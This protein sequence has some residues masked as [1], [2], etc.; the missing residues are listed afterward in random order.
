MIKNLLNVFLL[1]VCFVYQSYSQNKNDYKIII[2]KK[3]WKTE[4][5]IPVKYLDDK[6]LNNG[7]L[8]IHFQSSFDHD[9]VLIKKNDEIYGR[10]ELTSNWILGNAKVVVIPDFEE[11]KTLTISI[12]GGKEAILDLNKMNQ[13]IITYGNKKLI[14]G[15][16]KHM[17][18][19]D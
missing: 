2:D 13:V 7:K 10:Y 1:S 12:N 17:H 8:Y 6:Y 18:Y 11:I 19:Y 5:I 15:Y 9:T 3:L 16:S 14:I 4:K